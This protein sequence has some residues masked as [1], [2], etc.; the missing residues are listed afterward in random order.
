MN[1]N[2][3]GF[4]GALAAAAAG[5]AIDPER[6]LWTPSAKRIFLPSPAPSLWS[7]TSLAV[8]DIFTIQ[9]IY[10]KNPATGRNT[11]VPAHFVIT[12]NVTSGDID[13]AHLCPQ[14]VFDGVYGNVSGVLTPKARIEPVS[15]WAD[16]SQPLSV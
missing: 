11:G 16:N 13:P 5:L 15:W 4:I 14:M 6:L 12:A 10:A 7:S 1:L 2:R 8:G 9:G 3:R